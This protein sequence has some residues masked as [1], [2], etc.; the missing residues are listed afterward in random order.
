ML[1]IDRSFVDGLGLGGDGEATGLVEAILGMARTLRMSTVAEGIEDAEQLSEL[2]SLGC[3]N[4]QGYL[5]SRPVPAD[6]LVELLSRTLMP[7]A[8]PAA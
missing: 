8:E 2:A 1:K 6:Q 5:L 3:D 7:V 4:G